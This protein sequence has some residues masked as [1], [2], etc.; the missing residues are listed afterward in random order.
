MNRRRGQSAVEYLVTHGWALLL[1]AIVIVVLY[2]L[3]IF[4]PGR[5]ATEE[6]TFQPGFGCDSFMLKRMPE[7]F[8]HMYMFDIVFQN[9]LGYD[10]LITKME[11]TTADLGKAGQFTCTMTV[12]GTGEPFCRLDSADDSGFHIVNGG[13]GTHRIDFASAREA[14]PAVGET[15]DMKFS[16]TYLN[17]NTAAKYMQTKLRADCSIVNGATSHVLAGKITARIERG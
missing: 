7:T 1:L 14:T 4:N 9:G 13:T 15:R 3:G 6:C 2:G 12:R 16:I 5:Y 11:V 10:I 17:C 8:W